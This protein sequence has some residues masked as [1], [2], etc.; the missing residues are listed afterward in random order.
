MANNVKFIAGSFLIQASE[1][2]LNGGSSG[3][4][5]SE[6]QN[7]VQPKFMWVNGKQVPYVSSQAWKHWL[8]DTLIQETKWPASRLRAIGWND[9]GNTAKIA[10]MLNPVD[11]PED[12]IFGYMY[13]HSTKEPK[14]LTDEQKAIVDTL[15][16]EQLVRPSVFLASLLS[17]IQT[18]GTITRDEAFVHLK[19]GSNPLPYTTAFYNADMNAIFGIDLSRLGMFDNLEAKDKELDP[20]L[21]D[22]ALAEKKIEIHKPEKPKKAGVAIYKKA[23]LPA[24]QKDVVFQ[25]FNAIAHLQGGAKMA[26]F[27]VDVTPKVIIAAGLNFKSPIFSD[28]FE[29]GTDKPRLKIATLK[30][31]LVDYKD[32]LQTPVFIGLRTG[33]LENEDEIRKLAS[34]E[35][36]KGK[37]VLSTP[38]EIAAKI[39]D[40]I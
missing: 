19:D 28:V 16:T 25:L 22:K 17:A 8:R 26:Q 5:A 12:D 37:I 31:L 7:L 20:K 32:R 15:P 13:A 10:G 33:Y 9:K 14:K 6:D 11:Y 18:K 2:F 36:L 39:R 40:S 35:K 3:G 30:E 24:Y 34:D 27:G 23:N 4:M 38:V 1:A 21:I 29:V